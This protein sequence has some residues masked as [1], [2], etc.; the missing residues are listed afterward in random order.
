MS[1]RMKK[2]RRVLSFALAFVMLVSLLPLSAVFSALAAGDEDA[3]ISV[4][5]TADKETCGLDETAEV[6]INAGIKDTI[7][8]ATVTIHFGENEAA[9]IQEPEDGWSPAEFS[10][11]EDGSTLTFTLSA[12]AG[13]YTKTFSVK[14]P[15]D[16][17]SFEFEITADETYQD[18]EHSDIV[19]S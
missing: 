9:A 4:V 13:T 5:M 18:Q 15:S 19:V 7:Q 17:E 3:D 14:A 6:T 16:A 8:E 1:R 12:D 10:K 2:N 11:V